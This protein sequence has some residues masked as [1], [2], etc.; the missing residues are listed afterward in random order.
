MTSGWGVNLVRLPFQAHTI[1]SGNG[2]VAVGAMLAGLDATVAAIT[3]SS[4]NNRRDLHHI[5]LGVR[6]VKLRTCSRTR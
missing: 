6:L 1:L 3:E 2:S 5:A 4:V